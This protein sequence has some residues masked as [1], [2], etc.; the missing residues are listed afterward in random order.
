MNRK[1][2]YPF[3]FDVKTPKRIYYL[4]AETE[5]EMNK[6]VECVCQVCSLKA[7]KDDIDGESPLTHI[8][9]SFRKYLD[10]F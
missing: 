3:M 6:W 9:R 10:I 1:V 8:I 7:D 5:E 2:K 4:A